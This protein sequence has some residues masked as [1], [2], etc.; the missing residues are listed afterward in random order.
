MV[1]E[2]ELED[3]AAARGDD[4]VH[5]DAGEVRAEHRAPGD[6]R[7]GVGGA[8]DVPPGGRADDEPGEVEEERDPER[9]PVHVGE[10]VEERLGRVD[11]PSHGGS[12]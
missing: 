10:V 6:V 2:V 8:D 11:D 9:Q 4:R 3:V 1:D 12:A 7:L 5:A